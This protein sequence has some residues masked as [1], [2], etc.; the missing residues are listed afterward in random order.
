MDRRVKPMKSE[1]F[2]IFVSIFSSDE[3]HQSSD[4]DR[5][6]QRTSSFQHQSS[7]KGRVWQLSLCT[8]DLKIAMFVSWPSVDLSSLDINTCADLIP[9]NGGHE[10][11]WNGI[12]L[13]SLLHMRLEG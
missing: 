1:K 9:V 2:L 13:R 3:Q 12:H 7:A 6:K 8:E 11:N 5:V 4:V 10:V